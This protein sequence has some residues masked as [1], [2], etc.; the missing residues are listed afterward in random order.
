[1]IFL[2]EVF[3][4]IA[5]LL[6]IPVAIFSLQILMALPRYHNKDSVMFKRPTI[7][8]LIPAHNESINLIPTLNSV[9][10]QL[11][12]GDQVFVIADNC[13]DNT[14]AI[15]LNGGAQVLQRFDNT[16]LGKGYALDFGIRHIEKQAVHPAVVIVVDADCLLTE[17]SLRRL[18]F[19]AVRTGR[20]IQALYLMHSAKEAS[21]KTKIAEFAWV[22]K[23]W[24][25]PLGFLR[26]GLPCQLMGTGMA[27]PWSLI[28][29][30]K[31]AN[32]HIVEDLKLGLDFASMMRSPKFCPEAVVTSTF[33][34]NN[35]GLMSQRT[36]WEHGHL[37]MIVSDG[38]KLM[39]QSFRSLNVSL[40]ALVVDMCVPP[41]ALL[42]ILVF[43][44]S[45]IALIGLTFTHH[46]MPWYFAFANLICLGLAVFL[47]WFKF[48]RSILSFSDL[49]YIP[50]YALSKIPLY[51]Q[52]ITRR[53]VSWVR[54]RRD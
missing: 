14:A 24:A 39:W 47:A 4:I 8:V 37:S 23:N 52:F 13:T 2:N 49:V 19:E 7:A 40:L 12:K 16:Q 41:L 21:L 31:L 20:P 25:R 29:H 53:Q 43:V 54:S 9:K 32:G 34:I 27:F 30:A 10:A 42:A 48:G 38:P 35:D 17:K 1:M 36:R 44:A 26:L 3:F 50:I 5:L 11:L 45:L 46:Y 51:F 22:V 18:A 6:G 28:R 15:A 33:P